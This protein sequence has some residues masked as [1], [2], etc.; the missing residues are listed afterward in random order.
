MYVCL[1]F[2]LQIAVFFHLRAVLFWFCFVV[3]FLTF[4]LPMRSII[5]VMNWRKEKLIPF[6]QIM[7]E[8]K[9]LSAKFVR[10]RFQWP[11]V[12][13]FCCYWI[14]LVA[15][16]GAPWMLHE[17]ARSE[18]VFVGLAG[19]INGHSQFSSGQISTRRLFWRS[20]KYNVNFVKLGKTFIP[21]WTRITFEVS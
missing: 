19:V 3:V 4:L 13:E 14:C 21:Q 10:S 7:T 15:E 1:F 18:R 16:H 17:R 8:S 9:G 12:S 5:V 2:F 6:T 11:L 20:V